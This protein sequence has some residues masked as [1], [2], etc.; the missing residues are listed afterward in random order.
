MT[1]ETA[2]ASPA[3][4]LR[5]LPFVE[6]WGVLIVF[7]AMFAVFA[8]LSPDL[9]LTWTNVVTIFDQTGII[10][11]L[12][13]GLTFVLAVGEFDLSF[14]YL[15]GLITAATVTAMTTTGLGVLP[16]VLI[17]IGTGVVAGA[18]NGAVVSTRRASSFIVTLA[19]GSVYTGVM[20][21]VA[22]PAPVATGVPAGFSDLAF[23]IGDISAVTV[24]AIVVS[25]VAAVV[26]RSTV[27]GRYVQA[28]G[29]NPDAAAIAGV[30]VT[31]IRIGAFVVLGFCVS[32][33]AIMQ[34]SISSAHYPDSGLSLFL[35]PFVAA[36]IGTSVLGRGQFNILGTVIGALFISTLQTGLLVQNAAVWMISLLE[37]IVLLA[38][39]LVAAQTRRR[40]A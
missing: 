18:I 5:I 40:G 17:G 10:I 8:V 21:A 28:T 13:V 32:V 24:L 23:R 25:L 4:S 31:A 12:A 36:F 11:L 3:T 34:A 33:A 19:L 1:T 9:F 14:P 16:A 35:P 38:A 2:K 27:F 7:A 29:S 15:F 30:N 26:L 20:I 37:G 39:V 22:G 6:R